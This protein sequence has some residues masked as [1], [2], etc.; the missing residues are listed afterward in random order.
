MPK[1]IPI[2][3]AK[4]EH[5][6]ILNSLGRSNVY[7]DSIPFSYTESTGISRKENSLLSFLP[8][9]SNSHPIN[10]SKISN[11]LNYLVTIKDSFDEVFICI[12]TGDHANDWLLDGIKERDLKYVLGANPFDANS[13][14]RMRM[15][16]DYFDFVTTPSIGS[17]ILYAAYSGCKVSICGTFIST[18]GEDKRVK[19]KSQE[20]FDRLIEVE[21]LDWVKS[22][23]LFLF[24]DHPK[25][26][27]ERSS[28]AKKE[29][30]SNRLSNDELIDIL[31]WNLNGQ[32]KGYANG[33]KNKIKRFF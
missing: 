1:D 28:W 27:I 13:L 24:Y 20:Y 12:F 11:Y 29:I 8:H 30:S 22:N 18:R 7:V 2:V 10:Q 23:F 26:A 14:I 4:E 15:L 19:N 25:D 32:V 16:L 21:S 17:H 5:K 6:V 9:S 31:G 3:V 33:L